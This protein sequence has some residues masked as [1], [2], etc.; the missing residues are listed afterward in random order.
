MARL[1]VGILAAWV[2]LAVSVPAWAAEASSQPVRE[3]TPSYPTYSFDLTKNDAQAYTT[4]IPP[5]A[6]TPAGLKLDLK[7]GVQ[8]SFTSKRLFDSE[9]DF[10]IQIEYANRSDVGRVYVDLVLVND[11]KKR[12]AVGSYTNS[13]SLKVDHDRAYLSYFKDGVAAAGKFDNSMQTAIGSS[14]DKNGSWEW[15]RLH[16]ADTRVW[17]LQKTRGMAYGWGICNYPPIRFNEDCESFQV[18]FT[19]RCDDNVT[20]SLLI[21]AV[22][23][24]GPTAVPRDPTNRTFLFDFG[25]LQQELED[26][27][28]PVNEYTMYAPAKGFGWIIPE[29]EKVYYAEGG[30]PAMTDKEIADAGL[31]PIPP[32]DPSGDNWYL[33]FLRSAYWLESRDKKVLYSSSAGWD[34]VDFFKKYLDL[35]TPLERDFVG[36]C[37]PYHYAA[38]HLYQKDVEER[39]GSLY[40]DDDLS[41]DFVVDVP[42]GNYNVIMGI[43]YSGSLFGSPLAMCVDING[44]MRKQDLTADYMRAHQY[45]VRNVLVEN[46]KMD[47]HFFVD[48]RKCMDPYTNDKLHLGWHVNFIVI[49]PAEEKDLMNAWEW[50]IIKRRGEIIRRV[51][52]VEGAPS[53]TR[54]EPLSEDAKAS[55]ITLNGKPYF[56]N[57]L[58]YNHTKGDTDYVSYY[59]LANNLTSGHSTQ[60]SDHFFKPDW[61]KM[62]YSDDYPWNVVDEM[63]VTYTWRCLTSLVQFA[64]LSFVPHAVQGEGNP[65]MDSRG[66]RNPYNI[67]PPLNSALGKEI[68]REAFTMIS[69]QIG[70]H[71]AKANNYIYEELW[72]PEDQGFDDQSYIQYWSWLQRKYG[73]IEALNEDWKKTYKSFDAILPPEPYKV[74]FWDFTPEWVNFRKFRA[75]AQQQTVKNAVDLTH[76]LE[77]NLY[78]WGIKGDF[79]TQSWYTGEFLDMFGWYSPEV[80]SSV[81]RYFGK[82]AISCGYMLNCEYAYLDGRKQFD[83]KPGPRKYMG[84]EEVNTVY[85]KRISDVF[86]GSKGFINEWYSDG[87][88]HSFHR[89]QMIKTLA[90]QYKIIHW[91]GQLAFYEPGAFEGPPVDLERQA[92]YASCANQMLY[93]LAPLWLPAKPLQPKALV[94]MSETSFF[95]DFF[96]PRPYADLEQ[97]AMR[98]LKASNIPA[99]F[100]NISAV[101]D[102]SEYKL[103]I[104][105]D[106][107]QC[108]PKAQVE[109]IRQFVAKGGK[110]ILMDGGGMSTDENPRRWEKGGVNP[111]KEFADL[112]GYDLISDSRWH[113]PQG[114]VSASFA[115]TDIAPEIADGLA[116]GEWDT[117]FYYKAR[118]GS[119][120]FLRG[121]LV[122][123]NAPAAAKDVDL[124]ILAPAGNMAVVQLPK[125]TPEAA[126]RLVSKFFRKLLDSWNI[127]DRVHAAGVEDE[128]DTYSGLLEGNGYWLAATCNLSMDKPQKVSLKIKGLPEGDYTVEDVTGDKPDLMKKADG[129]QRLKSDSAARRV[130]IDYKLSAAQLASGTITV[131]IAPKQA[132]VYLIRPAAP[133]VWVSI[134]RPSIAGFLWH[135]VTV[136]YGTGPADKPAA[137][138]I[139]AALAKV[140]VKA[141]LVP[142]SEIKKKKVHEEIRVKPDGSS[143]AYQETRDK[144]YVVDVFD[145]EILDTDNSLILVGSEETNELVK[146]LNKDGTFAYDKALEKVDA[147]FPGAGRGVVSVVESINAPTYDPRSQSRDAIVVGGSDAE[148]TKAAAGEFVNLI[149][150]YGKDRRQPTP[151]RAGPLASQ[152][153]TAA[154]SE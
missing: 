72:H 25:P 63:N 76:Q 105:G 3:G 87:M 66:R 153:A 37:R 1:A 113:M 59:C 9:F 73:T 94:A 146:H 120:V 78:A 111:L 139:S 15:L 152:P 29:F 110:L 150:K 125:G 81:A 119:K 104:V 38:S 28:T 99:D 6:F 128:W 89:T 20:G 137:E 103:I 84:K 65:T 91:T 12:K 27:F 32:P 36:M 58:Q 5:E 10:D 129:G 124:G 117:Q 134:W 16:K 95:L 24:S 35:K 4:N 47:F 144:W 130:K 86:K 140:G 55:F 19:V 26:G 88:C 142:A 151:V 62:S 107:A 109:R 7:K 48:V 141:T 8:Y 77:P 148:G 33:G 79:G 31:G 69:N 23:V 80:A 118:E 54:H 41:G 18:G 96:G 50:K 97:V 64:V 70:Q 93:R 123:P 106:T 115:K 21:K 60:G 46:G 101:K 100:M 127:D 131:D 116:V 45:P 132:R 13:P 34:Y 114:K 74:E 122:A 143:I 67:Q 83:H 135:P 145:N 85:S 49:L 133:K 30:T 112:G 42:N 102:L 68:Q 154:N 53:Q 138:A 71:P 57:S 17:F 51:T 126:D 136:A 40:I 61:E 56:Y 121:K 108:M 43:G 149:D 2:I 39:R 22:K 11:E 92:I 14:T 75:W 147:A 90:P 98:V 52:F 82:A 44:R